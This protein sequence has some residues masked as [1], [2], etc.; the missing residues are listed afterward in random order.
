MAI[1]DFTQGREQEPQGRPLDE[2]ARDIDALD[3]QMDEL[4]RLKSALVA[5]HDETAARNNRIPKFF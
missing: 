2:I 4:G 3:A 5:E 1:D